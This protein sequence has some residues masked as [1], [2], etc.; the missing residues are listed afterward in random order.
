M[1]EVKR[2]KGET[3]DAL[4]RRFQRRMKSSGKA[5]QAKKIR[6]L[7]KDLKLSQRRAG[8]LRREALKTKY[9]YELKAGKIKPDVR[10]GKG[11]R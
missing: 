5:L 2:K 1:T 8:A 10:K 4:Y 7:G 9:E 6:F 3:F 11:R